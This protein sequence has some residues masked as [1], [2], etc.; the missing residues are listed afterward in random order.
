M[1]RIVDR[2]V[3][4]WTAVDTDVLVEMMVLLTVVV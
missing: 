1:D 2:I 4:Y 3:L